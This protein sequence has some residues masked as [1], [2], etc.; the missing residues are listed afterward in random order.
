MLFSGRANSIG[1]KLQLNVSP[2][3]MCILLNM[4]ELVEGDM[5]PFSACYQNIIIF[6]NGMSDCINNK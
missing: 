4:T 1:N 5:P 3:F 2:Q 6:Q